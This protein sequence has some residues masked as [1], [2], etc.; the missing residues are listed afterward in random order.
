M[1]TLCSD[2]PPRRNYNDPKNA[3]MS[4]PRCL[5]V[6][7]SLS[8]SRTG[9]SNRTMASE[10]TASNM[11]TARRELTPNRFSEENQLMIE[12]FSISLMFNRD[13]LSDTARRAKLALSL[14]PSF[15]V[16]RGAVTQPWYL[17]KP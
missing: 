8:V 10:R 2:L 7:S 17:P 16:S 1:P 4:A 15:L 3:N 6:G 11:G 12:P 13:A 5:A 14:A 9:A